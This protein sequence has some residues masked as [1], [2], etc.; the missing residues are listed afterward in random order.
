MVCIYRRS[1]FSLWCQRELSRIRL[2][3]DAIN[4][5]EINARAVQHRDPPCCSPADQ[6]M[7]WLLNTRR[8][9]AGLARNR[10]QSIHGRCCAEAMLPL[11]LMHEDTIV[12]LHTDYETASCS[13]PQSH[14]LTTS[15]ACMA[16]HLHTATKLS[17]AGA[18]Q[19]LLLFC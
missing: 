4:V 6:C 12:L 19:G 13:C 3:H 5:T 1:A 2:H 8:T 15:V 17:G 10:V 16:F 11:L 7:A 14:A 18:N 9:E